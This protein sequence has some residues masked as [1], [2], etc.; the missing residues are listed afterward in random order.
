M[1]AS[2]H[3]RQPGAEENLFL[4]ALTFP[5]TFS[6]LRPHFLHG[7]VGFFMGESSDSRHRFCGMDDEA[8]RKRVHPWLHLLRNNHR[9]RMASLFYS[10][11]MKSKL[12]HI[13]SAVFIAL[14]LAAGYRA[15]SSFFGPPAKADGNKHEII[16]RGAYL[17][18]L[19]GCTDCHTPKVMTEKGPVDDTSRLFSGHPADVVLPPPALGAENPW[20]AATAGMTAWTG[21]WGISYA[22]N[23]TPDPET[24]MGSW[25]EEEFIQTLRTGKHRGS[26]RAIL[27]PMPWQP[28]AAATQ[29][30]LSAIFAYLRSVSPV[31]NAVPAPQPPPAVAKK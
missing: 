18:R 21:P 20:G 11:T 19:G 8:V 13:T 14:G 1:A 26:G 28:L 29:E 9:A 25:T 17:V 15:I 16:A 4:Q 6:A 27:P 12:S 23:L 3:T 5:M 30:D 7:Q 31:K 2:S 10:T 24:G 22:S